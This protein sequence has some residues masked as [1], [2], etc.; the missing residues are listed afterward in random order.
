[1]Q[2]LGISAK[3]EFIDIFKRSQ[4][5][6][7]M[8]GKSHFLTRVSKLTKDQQRLKELEKEKNIAE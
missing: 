1:M 2:K 7:T 8:K 3:Q 5:I 6:S 4:A